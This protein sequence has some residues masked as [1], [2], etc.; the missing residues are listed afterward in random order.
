MAKTKKSPEAP[1]APSVAE[2]LETVIRQ[3][4]ENEFRHELEELARV[5]ERPRPPR[6]K[7]S[8]WAVKTYI[9]GGQLAGGFEIKPKYYGNTRLVEIAIEHALSVGIA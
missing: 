2:T 8:P 7:L 5:D 1:S 6:W 4:A 9:L 3:H